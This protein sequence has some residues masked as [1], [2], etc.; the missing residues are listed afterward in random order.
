MRHTRSIIKNIVIA[1]AAAN[2]AYA[3]EIESELP[4]NQFRGPRGDGIAR[5]AKLAAKFGEAQNVKWKTAIHDEGW[6]SPVVWGEQ[7]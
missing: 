6:S 2:V 7:V 4:W 5:H 3:Q 1:V